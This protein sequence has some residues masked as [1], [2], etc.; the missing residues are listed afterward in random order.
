MTSLAVWGPSADC[1]RLEGPVLL[2]KSVWVSAGRSLL[3]RASDSNEAAVVI[4]YRTRVAILNSTRC[5]TGSQRSGSARGGT[6]GRRWCRILHQ[7]ASA[8]SAEQPT[9]DRRWKC[10]RS[11]VESKNIRIL[12][13]ARVVKNRFTL[14]CGQTYTTQKTK[15]CS[16]TAWI[17]DK[18]G[19]LRIILESRTAYGSMPNNKKAMF[20]WFVKDSQRPWPQTSPRHYIHTRAVNWI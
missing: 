5:H 8:S 20:D 4:A 15:P 16:A 12:Y 10:S 7:V 6:P 11:D 18:S 9:T 13:L 14:I 2:T 1:Y 3:W 19:R 17:Y